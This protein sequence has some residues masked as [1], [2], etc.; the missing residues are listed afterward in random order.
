MADYTSSTAACVRKVVFY[1]LSYPSLLGWETTPAQLLPLLNHI[2]G[3]DG[4]NGALVTEDMIGQAFKSSNDY[5]YHTYRELGM[6]DCGYGKLITVEKPRNQP[7]VFK[8]IMNSSVSPNNLPSNHPLQKLTRSTYS[9]YVVPEEVVEKLK[10]FLRV[11]L[12]KSHSKSGNRKR[13]HKKE[14]RRR[15][16]DRYD[17]KQKRDSDNVVIKVEPQQTEQGDEEVQ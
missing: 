3:G 15:S 12:I 10:E 1:V 14:K 2:G 6:N 13:A 8:V 11:R 4:V 16:D 9:E 7:I 5:M 17:K